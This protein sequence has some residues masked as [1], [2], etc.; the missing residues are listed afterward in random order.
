MIPLFRGVL[1]NQGGRKIVLKL[2][3]FHMARNVSF[4]KCGK[5]SSFMGNR[6]GL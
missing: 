4:E 6:L 5:S 2:A 1:G 3:E